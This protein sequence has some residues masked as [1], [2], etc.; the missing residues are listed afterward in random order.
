MAERQQQFLKVELLLPKGGLQPPHRALHQHN[1]LLRDRAFAEVLC[2]TAPGLQRAR[3]FRKG[4]GPR[5]H[6]R[7]NR[8]T[9]LRLIAW[10]RLAPESRNPQPVSSPRNPNAGQALSI[11]FAWSYS[12]TS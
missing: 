10:K 1:F 8:P 5:G 6:S 12:L 11:A 3:Q 2:L 7:E 4:M 9:G